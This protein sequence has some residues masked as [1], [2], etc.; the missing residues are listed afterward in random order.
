[1]TQIK[2]PKCHT[3]DRI[4]PILYGMPT[5][6]FFEENRREDY[7]V[8]AVSLHL[9]HLRTPVSDAGSSLMPPAKCRSYPKVRTDTYPTCSK[10]RMD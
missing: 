2:C 6:E 9:M 5:N 7:Y 1:M 10:I 8:V 3:V 4:I